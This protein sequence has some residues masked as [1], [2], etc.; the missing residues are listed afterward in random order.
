MPYRQSLTFHQQGEADAWSSGTQEASATR[1]LMPTKLDFYQSYSWCLNPYPTVREAIEHLRGEIDRLGAVPKGWQTEEV[2]TNIFLLSCAL[3]N[4][5]DEYLRGPTLRMPRQLAALRLGRSARWATDKLEDILQH[6]RRQQV[7]RWKE[8]WQAGLDDFL[9]VLVAGEAS[10]VT[11]AA[12]LA[13][14]LAMQ[15]LLPPD[16]QAGHIGVPTPFRRLYLTHHDVLAL[17]RRFVSRFPDRSRAILLVG[18]RTSG[19]YFAPLL[20]AFLETEGYQTVSSLTVQPNK[21]PG[22]W[23]REDL[24]RCAQRG[25]TALIL[26]DAPYTAGTILLAFDLCRRAGFGSGQWKALVPTHPARRNWFRSLPHDIVVSLEPEQWHKHRLLELTAAESRLAEYFQGQG[27]PSI[28]VVAS[29][30]AKE[31]N[32]RLQSA[33][34]DERSARLKRVFEVVMETPR[35]KRKRAM[36][37]PRASAGDGWAT[38]LFWPGVESRALCR[39]SS[40]CATGFST[41]NGF[42]SVRAPRTE[43]TSGRS[44]LQRPPLAGPGSEPRTRQRFA[45]ASTWTSIAGEGAQQG[46]RPLRDR[47]ADAAA[48]SAAIGRTAL[49][50]SDAH[51]WQYGMHG[52]VT[53]PRNGG[54][55]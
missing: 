36:F 42:R 28:R 15:S 20:R 54:H 31:F 14:G 50:D 45:T 46:L 55:L 51:R 22:R 40:D 25:Y 44:G 26:D 6:R 41:R 35:G 10:D 23:G 33:S 5:V 29:S 47:H 7:R 16:L 4:A 19:S 49:P 39:Q 11:S 13:S 21:G 30:A 8:R 53:L 37:W 38:T 17:G 32:A 27:F 9:S 24:K 12:E 3:L 48:A 1:D 43:M 34:Y 52:M 18:L 2:A